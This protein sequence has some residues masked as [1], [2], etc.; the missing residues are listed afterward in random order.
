MNYNKGQE[1]AIKVG[2]VLRKANIA[3]LNRWEADLTLDDGTEIKAVD[4]DDLR[5]PEM[6]QDDSMIDP[7]WGN[8]FDAGVNT[9]D[10][11]TMLGKDRRYEWRQNVEKAVRVAYRVT[12]V[13]S[14]TWKLRVRA[15]KVVQVFTD[16]FSSTLDGWKY[17]TGTDGFSVSSG[18]LVSDGANDALLVPK[19]RADR[20]PSHGLEFSVSFFP[21]SRITLGAEI[22]GGWLTVRIYSG[23]NI[24]IRYVTVDGFETLLETINHATTFNS[25]DLIRLYDD[26]GMLKF[27]KNG[28]QF[29]AATLAT[30]GRVK[31]AW[32]F[33]N[34]H[35]FN[36]DNY[37]TIGKA[38]EVKSFP[39]EMQ[40]NTRKPAVYPTLPE[41]AV[42]DAV[43][44]MDSNG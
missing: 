40:Y 44:L 9:H 22:E 7:V 12:K 43:R 42:L 17:V 14:R 36:V 41:Q 33:H 10:P 5:L 3:A 8:R 32:G 21:D 31:S 38:Q 1:V 2:G 19:Y 25:N 26:E 18:E 30:P 11:H 27:E 37:K 23:N 35:E 6:P 34:Q 29:A 4:I 24:E 20:W 16:D 39:L 13:V 28:E 15:L